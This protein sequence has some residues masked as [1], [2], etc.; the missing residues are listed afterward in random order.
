ME[1]NKQ[2]PVVA[3]DKPLKIIKGKPYY[4]AYIGMSYVG[5][6]GRCYLDKKKVDEGKIKTLNRQNTKFT[7]D[8]KENY[9]YIFNETM[10]NE[11]RTYCKCLTKAQRE[12]LDQLV[13][14]SKVIITPA[15]KDKKTGDLILTGKPYEAKT[16]NENDGKYE[17][18]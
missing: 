15:R 10:K 3:F 8:E 13:E 6:G 16:T 17:D 11:K 4:H 7:K 14:D 9:L 12:E 18:D 1:T 5:E 2:K